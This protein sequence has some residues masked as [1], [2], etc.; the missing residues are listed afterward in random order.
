MTPADTT[1]HGSPSVNGEM[2]NR[3]QQLR[4]DNATSASAKSAR[5][6]GTSWLPWVLALFLGITWAGIGIKEYKGT[7]NIRKSLGGNAPAPSADPNAPKTNPQTS[8]DSP[9]G[10]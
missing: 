1:T 2:L 3:V 7:G 10:P 9:A 4:L 5:G 6:G 8:Q